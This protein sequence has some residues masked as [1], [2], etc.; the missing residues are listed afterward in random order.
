[1][2]IRKEERTLSVRVKRTE[3]ISL[4]RRPAPAIAAE[5]RLPS[6]SSRVL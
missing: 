4:A 6:C 5:E 2:A 1:M 3:G